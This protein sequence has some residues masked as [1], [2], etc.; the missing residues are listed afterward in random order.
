[1]VSG[2]IDQAIAG[3]RSHL[4]VIVGQVRASHGSAC[5]S[6]PHARWSCEAQALRHPL[7]QCRPGDLGFSGFKSRPEP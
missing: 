5:K 3:R 1:M 6:E 7:P 2:T 4:V